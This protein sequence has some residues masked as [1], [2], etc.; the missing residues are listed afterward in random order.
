MT[1]GYILEDFIE[2]EVD[3]ILDRAIDEVE[4]LF[5]DL[6]VNNGSDVDYVMDDGEGTDEDMVY[7]SEDIEEDDSSIDGDD[8]YLNRLQSDPYYVAEPL[9]TPSISDFDDSDPEPI[10]AEAVASDIF[11]F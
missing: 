4:E 9:T 8:Y 5:C 10:D 7:T 3:A 6:M 11:S 2:D 1:T